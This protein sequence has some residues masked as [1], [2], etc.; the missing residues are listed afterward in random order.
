MVRDNQGKIV[1]MLVTAQ[2]ITERKRLDNRLHFLAEASVIL[3]SSLDYPLTL[4]RIT[5]L[6]VPSF[7]DYCAA[8]LVNDDGELLP[9]A[10]HGTAEIWKRQDNATSDH[11]LEAA[12]DPEEGEALYFV[13]TGLPDGSHY[14]SATLEEHNRAVQ[15]YLER[16]RSR[17]AEAAAAD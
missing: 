11:S 2:D 9:V 12:V 17:A 3:S 15:T 10:A 16:I 1:G 4:T 8:H 14:F 6:A 5:R 7:A 13:A